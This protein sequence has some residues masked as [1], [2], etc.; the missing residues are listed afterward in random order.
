MERPSLQAAAVAVPC[1]E[2]HAPEPLPLPPLVDDD[3]AAP[4]A[5]HAVPPAAA[6]AAAAPR[7]TRSSRAALDAEAPAPPSMPDPDAELKAINQARRTAPHP[8]SR[9]G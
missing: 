4:E 9:S 5:A 6:D 3:F 8:L 2:P 1:T 7:R